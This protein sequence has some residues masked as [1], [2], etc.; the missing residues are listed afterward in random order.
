MSLSGEYLVTEP[1]SV[2]CSSS[3]K[4]I[5]AV[6]HSVNI[7]DMLSGL[8][9]NELWS[10]TTQRLRSNGEKRTV[11][12]ICLHRQTERELAV[13]PFGYNVHWFRRLASDS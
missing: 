13:Q 6:R 8:K 1:L 5:A 4:D 9:T 2:L 7:C 11:D 3:W 10:R 12:V